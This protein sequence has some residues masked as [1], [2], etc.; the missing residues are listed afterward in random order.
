MT[1]N[2]TNQDWEYTPLRFWDKSAN[3]YRFFAA[4]PANKSWKWNTSNDKVKLED[5]EINGENRVLDGTGAFGVLNSTSGANN[6]AL[7]MSDVNDEDLMISDDVLKH[8]TYTSDEVNLMFNH[9]LSRLN[10]GIRRCKELDDYI[11]KLNS[12]EIHNMIKKATFDESTAL[13]ATNAGV[14]LPGTITDPTEAQLL[15]YGTSARWTGTD[16]FTGNEMKYYVANQPL[17]IESIEPT[18]GTGTYDFVFQGLIIP[19]VI[20]YQKTVEKASQETGF[21]LDGSNADTDSKP[22]IVLDY[23]IWTKDH[24]SEQYTDSDP[25]V[26]GGIAQAGDSKP[27]S[28]KLD[29]YKYFYNLADVFNGNIDANNKT[30]ITFCEGWQNTLLITIKP[31]A[32]TFDAEVYKWADN[33]EVPVDIEL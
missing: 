32:I 14:Y 11:V 10:I 27:A 33:G 5:F 18:S 19:Q 22:Y 13:T 7:L 6:S 25:E 15:K 26:I 2:S 17:S 24:S 23:E 1:Y 31:T 29:G 20:G 9:I 28:Y 16:R 4:S 21:I 30:D 8:I 3:Y 12:L